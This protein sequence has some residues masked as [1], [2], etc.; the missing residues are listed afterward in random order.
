MPADVEIVLEQ[1]CQL[2][3]DNYGHVV[4]KVAFDFNEL[5]TVAGEC[6]LLLILE[7]ERDS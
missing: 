4:H 3:I 1:L 7:K 5:S 2:H 6:R